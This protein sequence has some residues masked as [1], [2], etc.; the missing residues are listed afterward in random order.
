MTV[1][2]RPSEPGYPGQRGRRCSLGRHPLP[3]SSISRP[4]SLTT[5]RLGNGNATAFWEDRWNGGRSLAEA[6]PVLYSHVAH[7]GATVKEVLQQGLQSFLVPR[8]TPAATTELQDVLLIVASTSLHEVQD[9]RHSSMSV[10]EHRLS[11]RRIYR[12][13]ISQDHK[14]P[15]YRFIWRNHAPPKVRFFAWLLIQD[16]VQHKSSLTK[17]RVLEE[18]LCDLCSHG[19]EDADHL[20][21]QCPFAQS[22]WNHIGWPNLSTVTALGTA[23]P[24][25]G[26]PTQHL[27]TMLLLCCWQLWKHRH[28]VVFRAMQ[29]S[30]PRLL[31]ACKQEAQ[32]WRCRLPIHSRHVI[33]FWCSKF[34]M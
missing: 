32:L 33:D 22:S 7:H 10:T 9:E 25:A 19:K 15:H 30:L 11:T 24:P 28:E 27:S 18:D 5:V 2:E 17:K 26:V 20:I 31:L 6:F 14:C 8:L 16:R 3:A 29:P 34:H 13:T 4:E 1:G 23:Q 21:W 12:A